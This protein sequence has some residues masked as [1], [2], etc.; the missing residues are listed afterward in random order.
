M[1]KEFYNTGRAKSRNSYFAKYSEHDGS[2]DLLVEYITKEIKDLPLGTCIL[3]LG[4]GNGY[5]AKRVLDAT[6]KKIEVYGIDLSVS[7]LKS[8]Q[9]QRHD[10]LHLREMDNL[11]LKFD[12]A[13]FD[14][15]MAKSV[16]NIS[17]R[18]VIRVL[19]PGGHFFYK[20]YSGGRGLI[21][22]FDHAGKTRSIGG[23][24]ILSDLYG[25]G[26]RSVRVEYLI[27]PVK[28]TKDQVLETIKTMHIAKNKKD[29]EI[30]IDAT[31]DFF[32]N[33]LSINILSDPF[34]IRAQ[35]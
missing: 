8:A 2:T 31:E 34:I 35:K 10:N 30:L 19:K 32:G 33:K 21:D 6:D 17:T 9:N 23:V 15:V 13:F 4:T 14:V 5:L 16:S 18:E 29:K 27:M 24:K 22:I 12:D 25:A 11:D 20:E 1:T 3:D 26:F 7:M 28:R